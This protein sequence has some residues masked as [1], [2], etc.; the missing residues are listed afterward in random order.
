MLECRRARRRAR[1]D[2]RRRR[3][4]GGRQSHPP[5]PQPRPPNRPDM[6]RDPRS[7][8][9]PSS[10][11]LGQWRACVASGTEG[12]IPRTKRVYAPPPP[13]AVTLWVVCR[14][15]LCRRT[16]CGP[17]APRSDDG[18]PL[19][20][21]TRYR[22]GPR[23][24]CRRARQPLEAPDAEGLGLVRA[25]A[26]LFRPLDDLVQRL[27]RY[28]FSSVGTRGEGAFDVLHALDVG[29]PACDDIR[30]RVDVRGDEPL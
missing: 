11:H 20:G 16:A 19:G 22:P 12:V 18:Q 15:Y 7:A 26:E 8:P 2:R 30:E 17:R 24:S 1:S 23:Y 29:P 9:P 13:P 3:S 14:R 27:R 4:T 6:H 21:G 25:L 5:A 10:G 28:A